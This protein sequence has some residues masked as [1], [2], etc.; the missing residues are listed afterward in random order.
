MKASPGE[1]EPVSIGNNRPSVNQSTATL[2]TPPWEQLPAEKQQEVTR[3]LA[4]MLLRQ[5]QAQGRGELHEQPS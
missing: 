3:I 1:I 5:L 2:P 4:G